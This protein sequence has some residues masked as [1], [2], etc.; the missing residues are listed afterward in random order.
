M[1]LSVTLNITRIRVHIEENSAATDVINEGRRLEAEFT[2]KMTCGTEKLRETKLAMKAATKLQN[3]QVL[4]FALA[5]APFKRDAK[6]GPSKLQITDQSILERHV[7]FNLNLI[8]EFCFILN[9]LFSL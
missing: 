3:P 5:A 4:G 8:L 6:S 9:Q 2:L 7:E 1:K